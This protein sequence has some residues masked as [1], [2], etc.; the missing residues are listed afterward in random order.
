MKHSNESCSQPNAYRRLEL[1]LVYIAKYII[2]WLTFE[3]SF[4]KSVAKHLLHHI[5]TE[6]WEIDG[7][8]AELLGNFTDFGESSAENINLKLLTPKLAEIRVKVM[9]AEKIGQTV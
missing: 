3:I 9:N 8:Y 1:R 6:H 4:W 2:L 7:R 5:W